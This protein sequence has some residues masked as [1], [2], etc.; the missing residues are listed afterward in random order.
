MLAKLLSCI[1]TGT[2][3]V[4]IRDKRVAKRP[5]DNIEVVKLEVDV[6]RRGS[7]PVIRLRGARA[8]LRPARM[9]CDMGCTETV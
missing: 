4:G 9:T 3:A 2:G 5:F 7:T 6:V 1:F 8:L